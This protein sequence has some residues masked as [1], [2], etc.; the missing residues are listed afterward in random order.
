M[1]VLLWDVLKDALEMH[2]YTGRRPW[3]DSTSTTP[4]RQTPLALWQRRGHPN[5]TKRSVYVEPRSSLLD[6]AGPS[7][8][9][10]IAAQPVHDG[11]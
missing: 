1:A 11:W 5:M 2:R 8:D 6:G 7:R 4:S 9:L 10:I 3:G